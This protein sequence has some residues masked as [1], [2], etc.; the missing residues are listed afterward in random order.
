MLRRCLQQYNPPKF[1]DVEA[2]LNDMH[3]VAFSGDKL[4]AETLDMKNFQIFQDRIIEVYEIF[5]NQNNLHEIWK[6]V[7]TKSCEAIERYVNKTI[8]GMAQL[9]ERVLAIDTRNRL[10]IAQKYRPD[11]EYT[12]GSKRTNAFTLIFD[13]FSMAYYDMESVSIDHVFLRKKFDEFS[14]A[15]VCVGLLNDVCVE[16]TTYQEQVQ[17]GIQVTHF[18][19]AFSSPYFF[20]HNDQSSVSMNTPSSSDPPSKRK[21]EMSGPEQFAV[22]RPKRRQPSPPP[23]DL[24]H[25]KPY[26]PS[27]I[28]SESLFSSNF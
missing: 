2:V 14:I 4:T 22:S 18:Q 21:Y 8:D 20:L 9:S 17:L 1:Q 6:R 23:E 28:K 15:S 13:D 19:K 27:S 11:N 12:Y 10:P 5:Y 16:E 25:P 24:T 3:Y 26:A 7:C